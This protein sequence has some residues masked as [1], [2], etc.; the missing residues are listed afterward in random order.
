MAK[1]ENETPLQRETRLTG[2]EGLLT[3]VDATLQA[4]LGQKSNMVLARKVVGRW[5]QS[6][7]AKDFQKK[8]RDYCG[9]LE[10]SVLIG[11]YMTIQR[12]VEMMNTENKTE[13]LAEGPTLQGGLLK[14]EGM[15]N[16]R[17]KHSA[18]G[19]DKLAKEK[20]EAREA[21]A[22]LKPLSLSADPLT[23]APKI[24]PGLKKAPRMAAGA[25]KDSGESDSEHAGPKLTKP[26]KKSKPRARSS[27]SESSRRQPRERSRS[28]EPKPNVQK[29]GRATNADLWAAAKNL[30]VQVAREEEKEKKGK[31]G[32]PV[33][34]KGNKS[35]VK[36]EDVKTEPGK[37]GKDDD[38]QY[39]DI[40]NSVQ[41]KDEIIE[42]IKA[43]AEYDEYE[44]TKLERDW[45]DSA[46]GGAQMG[47]E[48]I[49]PKQLAEMDEKKKRLAAAL[50]RVNIRTKAKNEANEMWELNRL[51]QAGLSERKERS[52]DYSNPDDERRVVVMVRDTTPPFLDGRF[53]F[54]TQTEPVKTVRDDTSDMA[55]LAKQGSRVVKQVREEGEQG[56]FRQRFWEIQG[57]QMGKAL[58]VKEK[59]G[60]A[61]DDVDDEEFDHKAGGQYG[62]ALKSQ[63]IVAMSEFA[64]TKTMAEQ[65]RSLPVYTVREEFLEL[66]R[67]HQILIV[68]GETGSGKT[69]QLTQYV[70]EGGYTV[71]G[72]VGCTQPR[73]VAAV[74][75]AKRVSEEMGT[76]LGKKVG[77]AI[78]F[79]DITSDETIIKYMTDGVLLRESLLEP[80]LDKY[81]CV[82][83]DEAHERSLNTDVLFGI[84]RK[85]VAR[86]IDFRLIVTSATMDSDKFAN[87]FGGVPTFHIPGRTFPVDT[88]YARSTATDYVD[89]AV[90]QALAIHVGQGEGDILIFMTGQEDIEATCVLLADR[91]QSV[92]EGVPGLTILPIYSQLASDLQAKIFEASELRKIIV[93][94]NIAET[95]LTVD[96]IKF[97]IDTGY[98]KLKTYNAKMGMD[99]LQVTPVSQANANQRRGR[100][101]RTGPGV[102]W[103]LYTE[104]AF[105]SELLVMTIPEIQRTNLS[106]VVLL[107]KSMGVKNLLEFD[108]MDPPPQ[109]T[110]LNSMFQL[111]MLGALDNLGDITAVGSKMSQ[112]PLD[113]P[114]SKM[115]IVGE[116]LG[117]AS[118]LMTVVS[119]LSVPSIFHRPKDRAEESDAA[120]EKFF[121]PE[122]DHLT[123]LN[124]YQQWVKNGYSAKW[125]TEHFVHQKSLK[126]VRE[127]RGQMEEIL[128]QQKCHIASCGTD[129]DVV[130]KAICAGYFHN[131]GKLRGIGEYV[132]LRTKICGHL[133]PTSALYGLGYTPDYVVYHEVTF[134]SKEYMNTVTAVEPYWLAELGPMFF[135]VKETGTDTHSK[136][137]QEQEEQRQMEYAQKLR[138]D[139]DRQAHEEELARQSAGG[140]KVTYMGEKREKKVKD[141]SS[142]GV[143]TDEKDDKDEDAAT[144]RR[145]RG[146]GSNG[147]DD[148]GSTGGAVVGGGGPMRTRRKMM[149]VPGA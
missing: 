23:D 61:E 106:N 68:V 35:A 57:S 127:V 44:E 51:N 41:T 119:M 37:K 33:F 120:R 85:V 110:I 89:A 63:K 31:V 73:R 52:L 3:S 54:T 113:P 62:A 48:E 53:V 132:N 140:G 77:Y 102:C 21:S 90:Q 81:S 95:S 20:R 32:A 26:G 138:D 100:A 117:C 70:H 122:S 115:L 17:R 47:G 136:K 105:F 7:D 19:L 88:L 22:P 1:L 55:I 72:L 15:V 24:V 134:T 148:G 146:G 141:P 27:S 91:V 111:W 45:Y 79:E 133:H 94:T 4:L 12:R 69:T 64:R 125:C 107:L 82:I 98:C 10:E 83:M 13:Q 29:G 65:R 25:D 2:D 144:K 92:G 16:F 139:L 112:F 135:S 8:A 46:E 84:L 142:L 108:F 99:S 50:E 14:R 78:R 93:A 18:L 60:D 76:E 109:D 147:A 96:G 87:F 123:L 118:E 66:L 67:E 42:K 131:A 39:A 124:V 126:K 97:V 86:R 114:L 28:R 130:R 58:G 80:D 145:R 59:Q 38:L 104:S 30:R 5:C 34:F 149:I 116:E 49:D 43:E 128:Q 36:K 40:T 121:T 129:W 74:S 103:R 137:R 71:N 9:N 75:V 143:L 6:K 11:F 56:K 101:G